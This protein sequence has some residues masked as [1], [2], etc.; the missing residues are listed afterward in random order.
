M[1]ERRSAQLLPPA[2]PKANYLAHKEEID[3]A[4]HKVLERGQYIL[5][6]EVRAFEQE[7]AAFLSVEQAIG[8]ASGTDALHL[9]LRSCGVGP[10]D[11]VL[12]VSHTAVA[13][14]A[15]IELAGATP[16]LVDID[17]GTFTM[18]VD[19]LRAAID[20][21]RRGGGHLKAIVPVHLYGQPADMP[22][23]RQLAKRHNL[24]VIE[25]SAQ[26]HGATLLGRSTGTLGD[27]AAFSFYPTKNL[28]A[29]GDGGA[30]VTNNPE[31][32]SRARLLREYGWR[33]RYVSDLP[34]MNTRLD[35]LQAAVLRV[36]LR[37]LDA[38]NSRRQQIAQLYNRLLRDTP[39]NLPQ[40]REGA[41]HVYHQ[42][43]VRC[44]RRDE[45]RA[46]LNEKGVATSIL[47]PLPVHLQPAYKGRVGVARGGVPHSE[48]ACREVLCLPMHPQFDDA[49]IVRVA[50]LIC[51][52]YADRRP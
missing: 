25:D 49:E 2:N 26:S 6:E 8:V 1:S 4:I 41:K 9:A 28:G 43:V 21:H 50:E 15:A 16:L 52:W 32:G 27:I 24:F 30:V 33:E 19:H 3:Q 35:E 22:G 40:V 39:L 5:G 37:Y 46:F 23:I 31:L 34:G 12:T 17:P 13:T 45:L 14:V 42:Y 20:D 51:R 44:D 11:V 38:E 10:K 29:L 7:F 48:H 36:K 47:Y 18:D